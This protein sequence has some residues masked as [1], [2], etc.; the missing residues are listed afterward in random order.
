MLRLPG[1]SPPPASLPRTY[2]VADVVL[3]PC[4]HQHPYSPLQQLHHSRLDVAREVEHEGI[5]DG[6][7]AALPH[8]VA[9]AQSLAHLQE[10]EGGGRGGGEREGRKEGPTEGGSEGWREMETARDW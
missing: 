7:V 9:N 1:S 8:A 6:V 4:V 10:R 3:V 2:P 5:V